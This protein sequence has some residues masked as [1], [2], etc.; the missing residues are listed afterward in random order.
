MITLC[1]LSSFTSENLCR[2]K[3]IIKVDCQSAGYKYVDWIQ[4]RLN[5]AQ[6]I[7]SLNMKTNIIIS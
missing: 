7:V 1:I 3:N 5:I 4:L 6:W 2:R